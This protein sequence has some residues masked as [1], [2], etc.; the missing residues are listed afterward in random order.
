MSTKRGKYDPEKEET[1]EDNIYYNFNIVNNNN[2]AIPATTTVFNAAAIIEAAGKDYYLTC[3]RFVLDGAT[4]PICLHKD[5][6]W[7]VALTYRGFTGKGTVTNPTPND[8]MVG[9]NLPAY[10]SYTDFL[11][12]VNEAFDDAWVA[13]NFQI[14]LPT[15]NKPYMLYNATT[16]ICTITA[17]PA[18]DI[19]APQPIGVFMN[20]ALY[21]FFDNFYVKFAGDEKSIPPVT[22]G[23]NYQLLFKNLHGSNVDGAGNITLTQEYSSLYSWF[24]FTSV[25]FLSNSLGVTPEFFPVANNTNTTNNPNGTAGNG[26]PTLQI[27]TD[28]QP[29]YGPGDQ[30]GPRSYLYYVPNGPYRLID[31]NNGDIKNM[32]I[33][34]QIRDRVGAQ[35]Q[36][37]VPPNQTVQVKLLFTRRESRNGHYAK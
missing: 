25:V 35:Y 36:Y 26:N 5:N 34:I 28:F 31:L 9:T 4:I 29:Y 6:H 33:N 37:Y 30:A 19:N 13:L 1:D 11:E 24:D 32:D 16:G 14:A 22:N 23:L 7:V 20:S 12:R 3:I 8:T 2:F 18:Y 17:D 27:L 15:L 10:Y 21:D